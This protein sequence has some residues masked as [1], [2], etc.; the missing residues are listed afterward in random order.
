MVGVGADITE[1]RNAQDARQ[2][3][4]TAS[5]IA[6]EAV[7]KSQAR[8]ALLGRIS[9]V[10]GASLDVT[11]TLQQVADLVV[12]EHLADW[13]VVQLPGGPQGI[14]QVALAHRDPAMIDLA[15]RVQEDY[16]PELREDSGL[17]MVMRTGEA[18][19]WPSVPPELV[20][21]SAQDDAHR[22]LLVSLSLSAAMVIPLPAA[23]ACWAP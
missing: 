1:Q 19:F 2:A 5:D 6:R 16:P 7:Q 14:S 10:L 9:G 22:E 12:R 8:L 23:G 18:E 13:C 20:E 15:R 11:T 17:G 21:A 3:A 4:E